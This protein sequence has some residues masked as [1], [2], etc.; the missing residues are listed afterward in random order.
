MECNDNKMQRNSKYEILYTGWR[1]KTG[2]PYLIVNILKTPRPN[3]V[4]IGEINF[5]FKNFIML[6]RHPA[7]TQ[8]LCD[9][10]IYLYSVDKRQ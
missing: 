7:K 6:W 8:L 5:L 9:A 3:C 10:Q 4:E 2:P 1:K